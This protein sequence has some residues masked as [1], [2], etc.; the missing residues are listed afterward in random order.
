LGSVVKS[1]K[2]RKGKKVY[3]NSVVKGL[4]SQSDGC[5]A[6]DGGIN[7]VPKLENRIFIAWR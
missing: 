6:L 5:A 3:R 7:V 1:K 2:K 4:R